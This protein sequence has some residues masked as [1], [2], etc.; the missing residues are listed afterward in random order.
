MLFALLNAYTFL[1]LTLA[2]ICMS[3]QPQFSL[4]ICSIQSQANTS[5]R[6]LQDSFL[7]HAFTSECFSAASSCHVTSFFVLFFL[8]VFFFFHCRPA[9]GP[10]VSTVRRFPFISHLLFLVVLHLRCSSTLQMLVRKSNQDWFELH[11]FST[12][13]KTGNIFR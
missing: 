1:A 11:L 13:F 6:I 10:A 9:V 8:F 5:F 12:F 2:Y 3:S 7:P 4:Q